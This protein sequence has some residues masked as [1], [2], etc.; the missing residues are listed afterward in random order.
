MHRS[1]SA[2]SHNRVVTYSQIECYWTHK[3]LPLPILS[4]P[5][6]HGEIGRGRITG[7][8]SSIAG[9]IDS[10]ISSFED[11]SLWNAICDPIFLLVSSYRIL[12]NK[13][14]DMIM[15][16]CMCNGCTGHPKH[17]DSKSCQQMTNTLDIVLPATV[18]PESKNYNTDKIS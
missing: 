4:L 16:L 7:D 10:Q 15:C 12:V 5:N 3:L 8:G 2:R 14:R 1:S 11:V 9:Q 6:Y 18:K 17:L 13:L